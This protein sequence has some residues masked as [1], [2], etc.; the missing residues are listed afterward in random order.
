MTMRHR[1]SPY[2][3]KEKYDDLKNALNK[4]CVEGEYA[5]QLQALAVVVNMPSKRFWVSPERVS[6]VITKIESGNGIP[7]RRKHPRREMYEELYRRYVA[8]VAE[9]PDCPKLDACYEIVYSPAPK[10]YMKPSWAEKILQE[11]RRQNKRHRHHH[12]RK[13]NEQ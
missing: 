7:L 13:D 10:F 1:E 12:L 6:E 9:H 5:T 8:F 2:E 3:F 4:A 11:G